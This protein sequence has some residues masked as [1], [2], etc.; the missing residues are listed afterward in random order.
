MGAQQYFILF[1]THPNEFRTTE[2]MVNYWLWHD[3]RDI[4]AKKEIAN[5]GWDRETMR[6]C[7]KFL[8]LTSRS[9]ASQPLLETIAALLLSPN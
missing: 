2:N 6:T 3:A 5:S 1:F 9:F 4:T 7:W 8:D